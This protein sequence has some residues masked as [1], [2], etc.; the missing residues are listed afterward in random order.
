[1]TQSPR[2]PSPS[3]GASRLN[4]YL[5]LRRL[6]DFGIILLVVVAGAAALAGV[7]YMQS[8]G[9]AMNWGFGPE[10]QCSWPGKGGP[11]CI[12]HPSPI[13]KPAAGG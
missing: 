12:K 13:D 5:L 9:R 11:V 2:R 4:A 8:S 7:A 6:R 3:P 1:M 10:W